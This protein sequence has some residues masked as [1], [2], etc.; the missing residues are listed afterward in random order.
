[1][2][3]RGGQN[4][5]NYGN[6]DRGRRGRGRGRGGRGGHPSGLSGPQIGLW[7]KNRGRGGRG[8]HPPGLTGAQIGLFYKQKSQETKI[9]KEREQRQEVK[10]TESHEKKLV[11]M[12][13]SLNNAPS[14]MDQAGGSATSNL[15]NHHD[16]FRL[17]KPLVGNDEGM[18]EWLKKDLINKEKY[19][20]TYKQM[21]EF[22]KKLPSYEMKD[23]IVQLIS[24]NQVVVISGETGCGKTTQVAQFVLD[25]AIVKGKGSTCR[26]VCTQPRRISAISIAERVS[27]ERGETVGNGST[28][29]QIR[30][31]SQLPRDQGSIIFCTTGVVLRWLISDPDLTRASHIIIDEIHERSIHSDFLLIVVRDILPRRPD[32]RVV[33]MSATLNAELFSQYFNNCPMLNIPGFT[34]PVRQHFL[35]EIIKIL[36][37]KY[38]PKTKTHFHRG[39]GRRNDEKRRKEEMWRDYLNLVQSRE[40][41]TFTVECLE[42]MDFDTID[43]CLVERLLM[44]IGRDMQDGAVLVFLPG[45]KDISTLHDMLKK[46]PFFSSEKF[47]VLPLHSLM[48]TVNQR[49]IFDR[50]PRGVRKI[51]LST[52]LAETSITIDDV[53][54]VVD[55]GKTKEK[56]FDVDKELATLLPVWGSKASCKQRKGRA[57]RYC[58]QCYIQGI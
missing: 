33:L 51:V 45:W 10:M 2:Y 41:D 30:L 37:Y 46:N 24:S 9:R 50:P 57:G 7:H 38:Q 4:H 3:N 17:P 58:E 44:Y 1:M 21:S 28:G 43:Y 13:E 47:L 42:S 29:Y 25:D 49:Q 53:V 6:R 12:L 22:R 55:C 18:N 40:K 52:N 19:N 16:D 23:K 32:L 27:E 14:S 54:F 8:G 39:R 11:D 15:D 48:P 26:V 35:E 34:F 5:G 36:S 20:Q 56:N 31:E